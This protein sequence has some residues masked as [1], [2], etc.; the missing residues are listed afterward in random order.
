[1]SPPL[2]EI[3]RRGRVQQEWRIPEKA[4]DCQRGATSRLSQD[5]KIV[6]LATCAQS[7]TFFYKWEDARAQRHD[8]LALKLFSQ[9]AL[10]LDF[11][12]FLVK[13]TFFIRTAE[14]C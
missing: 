12:F 7:T 1:M 3:A 11:F 14:M 9:L 6:I 13:T 5:I 8:F 2:R 4:E 10:R